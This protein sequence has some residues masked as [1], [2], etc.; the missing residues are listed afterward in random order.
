MEKKYRRMDKQAEKRWDR[1]GNRTRQKNKRGDSKVESND[2]PEISDRGGRHQTSPA[3][4]RGFEFGIVWVM[5][6]F[7]SLYR[8][9]AVF[10]LPEVTLC[11]WEEVKIKLLIVPAHCRICGKSLLCLLAWF[12][13]FFS[14][15][16][17]GGGSLFEP[18]CM[19]GSNLQSLALQPSSVAWLLPHPTP[20]PPKELL[21]KSRGIQGM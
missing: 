8:V 7:L 10:I 6:T 1:K 16:G 15:G 3:S 13:F 4:L 14:L 20:H 18:W 11:G 12:F 2:S 19:P 9:M 17:G 21:D 5:W